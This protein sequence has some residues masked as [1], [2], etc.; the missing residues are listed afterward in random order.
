[1][2]L[3]TLLSGSI[4]RYVF[5]GSAFGALAP[6]T[7][8]LSA[9]RSPEPASIFT[10]LLFDPLGLAMLALP[11]TAGLFA[12]RIER[13]RA[14]LQQQ[15]RELEEGRLALQMAARR[16]GVTGLGNRVALED[17]FSG[18][19][20]C[21][22]LVLD[23]DRF[24]FVN[25]TMGQAAGDELLKSLA[26][27]VA[28]TAGVRGKLYRLGGDEFVL[29]VGAGEDHA[30]VAAFCRD[31]E[32]A[33]AAPYELGRGRVVSGVSIG[34][35]LVA[36]EDRVLS[37]VLLRA[38][39]ALYRAKEVF[40]A[41]HCFYDESLAEAALLQ[42]EIERDLA[43]ALKDDEFYLEYQPI[44]GVESGRLRSFEAL[45]RWR[46]PVR[47]TI[48]PEVFIP[49][50]EK[51]GMIHAIGEWVVEHACREAARWPSPTGVGVN[52]SGDQFKD[53][54][55]VDHVKSCL[56][57][58]GLAPGRLTIEVT[59]AV[60][61]VDI[62]LVCRSLEELR[63]FGVR[64][65]LD[66]F[67]TGFSSIN[68]LRLFPLDQ[69]KIDRSFARE[70]LES[71]RDARL[72]DLIHRLSETFQIDTTIEGIET[73]SQLDFV[74]KLGISEAQG[75]LIS[76]PVSPAKVREMQRPGNLRFAVAG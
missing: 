14:H 4:G 61:S 60:F 31:L 73:E 59:E 44:I 18:S 10:D 38:R 21:A 46:H 76:R 40:G 15:I 72:I 43:R 64:V 55:F 35:T 1:M 34:V 47:G 62:N 27:R 51:T 30:G 42:S 32:A 67:G 19:A 8:I 48:S 7:Y 54:R 53:R 49:I 9:A 69:L 23:L 12:I 36:P 70:M 45:L 6:M 52:V 29:L 39:L 41:S 2:M 25:D 50:A 57:R 13:H 63:A 58:T 24:K 28:T 75:F 33:T 66:D 37:D 22:L 17:D 56:A 11:L 16:D 3:S 65:A 71:N 5:A 20:R 68:N 26:E 74:R